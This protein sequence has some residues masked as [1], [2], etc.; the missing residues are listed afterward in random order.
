MAGF[1]ADGLVRTCA[2]ELG[3]VLAWAGDWNAARGRGGGPKDVNGGGAVDVSGGG[4]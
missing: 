2:R 3:V 1:A 4:R